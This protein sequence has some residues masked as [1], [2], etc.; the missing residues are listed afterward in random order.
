M[1]VIGVA[2]G[3]AIAVLP[4]A[5]TL[6]GP[7]ERGRQ[8]AVAKWGEIPCEGTVRI[9][10]RHLPGRVAGEAFYRT[11]MEGTRRWDCEVTVD[12]GQLR[13]RGQRCAVAMHEFGHLFGLGHSP[14]PRSVMHSPL[15]VVPRACRR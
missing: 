2:I 11:D 7:I 15:S 1:S 4:T 3:A 10:R 8:A 14:D 12:V 13:D 9:L 6:T 5:P